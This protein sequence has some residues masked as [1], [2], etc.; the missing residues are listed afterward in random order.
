MVATD[1]VLLRLFCFVLVIW[2]QPMRVACDEGGV[3]GLSKQ[4]SLDYRCCYGR[5]RRSRCTS[6]CSSYADNCCS[7]RIGHG[8]DIHRLAQLRPTGVAAVA[9]QAGGR[10]AHQPDSSPLVV[11]GVELPCE[12]RVIAHSDGDV[13]YHSICDALFGA[14]GLPDIGEQFPDTDPKWKGA[15]SHT[16][17][18]GERTFL[19]RAGL[20]LFSCSCCCECHVIKRRTVKWSHAATTL[21][22]WTSP[23]FCR[24]PR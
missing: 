20:E 4:R 18:R 8:Y 16:F 11:G 14:L 6:S 13:V 2:M 7:L 3:E 24:N 12:L 23:S 10:E 19:T 21:S 15:S 5:T 1:M 22:T 17:L 9:G